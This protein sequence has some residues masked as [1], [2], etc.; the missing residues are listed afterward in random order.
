M[1]S[2]PFEFAK[3][4]EPLERVNLHN[5][6]PRI[7]CEQQNLGMHR[8]DLF[9]MWL[10]NRTIGMTFYL[11]RF[12]FTKWTELGYGCLCGLVLQVG[13][14]AAS[15]VAFGMGMFAGQGTLGPAKQRA[16]SVI[17]DSKGHDIHLRFHDTCIAYKVRITRLLCDKFLVYC[18]SIIRSNRECESITQSCDYFF[19]CFWF[20]GMMWVE[21]L[22]V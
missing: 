4:F 2:L 15:S 19:R 9:F 20:N 21:S 13:R 6:A 14:S 3:H 16:F 18:W 22:Y 10:N 5:I 11:L 17:T 1:Q 12:T 7:L 8:F